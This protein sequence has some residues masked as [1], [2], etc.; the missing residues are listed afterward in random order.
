MPNDEQNQTPVQTNPQAATVWLESINQ[1]QVAQQPVQA[2]VPQAPASQAP[3]QAEE[4]KWGFF[5]GIK[6]MFSFWNKAPENAAAPQ[7]NV[8]DTVQNVTAQASNTVNSAV[9]TGGSFFQKLVSSTQNLLNKTENFATSATEKTLQITQTI[10]DV[11]GKV[12]EKRVDKVYPLFLYT[13]QE[14]F[15][16]VLW[17]TFL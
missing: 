9:E 11:P 8:G 5:G 17:T 14:F 16:R 1:E 10:K 7:P 4:K 13:K 3:A 2:A 15:E 12:V 6:N